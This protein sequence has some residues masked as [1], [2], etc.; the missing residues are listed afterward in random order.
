MGTAR[1]FYESG[2]LKFLFN[3]IDRHIMVRLVEKTN[4]RGVAGKINPSGLRFTTHAQH[5][6]RPAPYV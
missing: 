5:Y 2:C 6:P 3:G 4:P 1:L